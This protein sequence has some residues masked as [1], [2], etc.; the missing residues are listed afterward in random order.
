MSKH[1]PG[2]WKYQEESDEYTHIVRA[3]N[4]LMI[5]HLSQDSSGV[6]ESNARLIAAAPDLLKACKQ[7]VS[8]CEIYGQQDST[9]TVL[10]QAIAKAEEGK[11]N[12][13]K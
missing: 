5:C 3:E 1:T 8:R 13:S 4:N 2:P 7:A 10:G 6:S 9:K 11:W 12:K